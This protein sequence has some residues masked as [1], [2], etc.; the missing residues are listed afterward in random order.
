MLR[1]ATARYSHTYGVPSAWNTRWRTCGA[2][3]PRPPGQ[4]GNCPK[5]VALVRGSDTINVNLL[6]SLIND[7][8]VR[9]VLKGCEYN[10]KIYIRVESTICFLETLQLLVQQSRSATNHT[11]KRLFCSVNGDWGHSKYPSF[12]RQWNVTIVHRFNC[13]RKRSISNCQS[14]Q[15]CKLMEPLSIDIYCGIVGSRISTTFQDRQI[16]DL[17]SA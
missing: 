13:F 15:W 4:L 14:P 3:I 7:I 16:D 1:R 12:P 2:V 9:I 11:M 6:M 5:W 10:K 17:L 8:K